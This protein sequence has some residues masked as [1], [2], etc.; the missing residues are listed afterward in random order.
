MKYNINI[1]QYAVIRNN[2][3]LDVTDLAIFDFIKDFANS[4][5]CTKLQTPE[6]IFFWLSHQLIINEMPILNIKTK[7]GIIKRINNLIEAQL[8]IRHPNTNEYQKPMYSFGQKYDLLTFNDT[9]TN[10]YTSKQ[11]FR[12]PLNDCLQ[13]PVNERLDDNNINNYHNI[14]ENNNK[15][16][17]IKNKKE[18]T[19]RESEVF[20]MVNG[21]DY[22]KLIEHFAKNKAYQG[23]DIVYY[24]H[25]IL[26][27]SDQHEKEK[28]TARGWLATFNTFIRRDKENNKIHTIQQQ[29]PNEFA[30]GALFFLNM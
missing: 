22:S 23:I 28:R 12:P 24:F 7:Q 27:W 26:D 21:D 2:L 4:K 19:F 17:K 13:V 5:A 1:N 3:Q 8:I 16:E 15:Q 25:C 20:Q 11:M 14:E 9:E 10:V 30:E 18:T 29:Q 6:G